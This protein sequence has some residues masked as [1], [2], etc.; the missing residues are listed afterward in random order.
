MMYRAIW[1]SLFAMLIISAVL[2]SW[3]VLT[4]SGLSSVITLS[5]KYVPE[6]AIKKV[7][8]R[9]YDGA[10]FEQVDYQVDESSRVSINNLSIS[11][12][13]IELLTGR[14]TI[15]EVIVGDV[16]ITQRVAAQR[17]STPISLPHIS[18]P[19]P[20]YV[21][22]IRVNLVT[23]DSQGQDRVELINGVNAQLHLRGDNLTIN[24][25]SLESTAKA[26]LKMNGSIRLSGDYQTA[27][28][29][30]WVAVD[31]VFKGLTAKGNIKGNTSI[32]RVKQQVVK[33][34]RSTNIITI[35][36]LLNKVNWHLEAKVDRLNLADYLDEQTG[37]FSD[38]ELV[39]HGD[40]NK[41]QF[42]FKGAYTQPQIK[43]LGGTMTDAA[44]K[45]NSD[46]VIRSTPVSVDAT[47]DISQLGAKNIIINTALA[48]ARMSFMGEAQ[49]Q[50]TR[51]LNGLVKLT[52][53]NP[54]IFSPQWPG[55]LSGSWKLA[56][57]MLS[58]ERVDIS[59]DGLD[60]NGTLRQRPIQL[61]T[62]FSYLN[63]R[64]NIPDFKLYS[65]RS[66]ITAS[67]QMKERLTLNWKIN[68][69]NLKD[70]YPDLSGKLTATGTVSGN[71][72]EP[73]I[74]AKIVANT[75]EYSDR[76]SFDKLV[77]DFSLDM[78][79]QGQLTAKLKVSSLGVEK[80]AVLDAELG[81][82]GT[83][84]KHQLTIEV[85]NKEAN[86]SGQAEGSF[87]EK[88]WQGQLA[89]LQL[90]HTQAGQWSL[91]ERGKFIIASDHGSLDKHCMQSQNGSVC[92]QASYSANGNWHS[93]GEFAS[94]PMT[95][96]QSFS[97]SLMPLQGNLNGHFQLAGK[98][99]YPLSGQ[100]KISLK[101]GRVS[102]DLEEGAIALRDANIEYQL[103]EQGGVMNVFAEP[104][105]QGVSALTG[106]LKI[107]SIKTVIDK[108]RNANL[109]GHMTMSVKDLSVFNLLHP[110]YENLK[111]QFN[112]DINL[113]GTVSKPITT[114]KILLNNAGVG[115]SNM[116]IVLSSINATVEGG[117]TRG[118]KLKYE[119]TSGEGV[120]SGDGQVVFA[121]NGWSVSST[122]KGDNVEL[123]NVPEAYLIASPDLLFKMTADS[124]SIEGSVKVPA[125]E[126]APVKLNTPVT[127][128]KD[129]VVINDKSTQKAQSFPTNVKLNF[130]LGEK[131]LVKGFGFS[132]RL[133]GKLLVSG[134][135]NKLLL[136]TGDIVIKEGSYTAYGQN[137]AIDNGKIL[138][139]GGALDN[140]NIDIKAARKEA[141]FT[142]GLQ[143][144]G[145][146]DNPQIYLFSS[147]TMSDDNVLAHLLLGRP[148]GEASTADAAMLA[149]AASG[150]GIKG[151]NMIGEQ[152]ANTFGLDSFTFNGNGD[153][154]TALQIGKYLS[155]NL[156]ISYG[157]GI[158]EPVSTVNLRYKISKVWSLKAES[159]VETG[160]DILYVR[161]R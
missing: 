132:G 74:T 65:G 18:I 157:I 37:Q 108:P 131:V 155:P 99:Q 109:S 97:K 78:S 36:D 59:V 102:L 161:E 29:Y 66:A 42:N 148:L 86:V 123:L 160:V 94:V 122:L 141:D 45:I 68:S 103:T 31:P 96:L 35:S 16:L 116:G 25:L 67:G 34:V 150:L 126:L 144:L 113:S 83:K 121:D 87:I 140:P 9:L 49:W 147:P 129:V 53:V 50:G 38:A 118:V 32:L 72:I 6:L 43:G 81:I 90:K 7:S 1:Q 23:I 41:V 100:G 57:E 20:L 30:E 143:L 3:L 104:D 17:A 145:P 10:I 55:E 76:I 19:W 130:I 106:Q 124:A 105:L 73:V 146:L 134:N 12:Q 70:F 48:S 136:G 133:T 64:L 44:A 89:Q 47:A 149:S 88:I 63:Q 5:Q 11:W 58:N 117:L 21:E 2:L 27:L 110:E 79:Q 33:P 93:N 51:S 71:P 101:E 111:G 8:G 91:S 69:P 120:I 62:N 22:N 139:S 135:T 80:S 14:L 28:T 52:K 151:G 61:K 46:L 26:S 98:D 54:A 39:A 112:A 95:L 60:V 92:L 153:Q 77:S 142:A 56:A 24:H 107:P 114:G 158:F 13:A 15:N 84:E 138:F 82:T 85:V 128:S 156:Y 152:I 154:N 159:G 127:V 40:L 125:A 75:V 137:L 119:A 4:E 115:L